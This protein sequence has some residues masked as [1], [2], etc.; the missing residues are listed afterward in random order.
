MRT[1]TLQNGNLI[2][3]RLQTTFYSSSNRECFISFDFGDNNLKLHHITYF[4]RVDFDPNLLLGTQFQISRNGKDFVTVHTINSLIHSG[5]NF[6][7]PE[8]TVSAIQAIRF[9]DPT[10]SSKC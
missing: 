5:W 9:F 4:P 2:H 1:D 10:G 7:V 3:D 6:F 8:T